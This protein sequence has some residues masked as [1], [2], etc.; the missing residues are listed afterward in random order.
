MALSISPETLATYSEYIFKKLADLGCHLRPNPTNPVVW[1]YTTF[2]GLHGILETDSIFSTHIAS[3][4][5]AT[6]VKYASALFIEELQKHSM[7]FPLGSAASRMIYKFVA[8]LRPKGYQSE[9]ISVRP[10]YLACLSENRDDLSQWRAY[11][12]GENGYALGMRLNDLRPHFSQIAPP[13]KVNYEAD[14]HRRIAA[15]SAAKTLEF[16]RGLDLAIDSAL[17]EDID[18]FLGVWDAQLALL[19]PMVKHPA[20]KGESEVRLIVQDHLAVNN[21]IVYRQRGGL[22][23]RHFPVKSQ[24]GSL[25]ISTVMVGPGRHQRANAEALRALL[26]KHERYRVSVEVSSSPYQSTGL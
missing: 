11:G 10:W 19:A 4:N 18:R 3:L 13:F 24:L 17:D 12:G 15:E 1:H 7:A 22:I 26:D 16:F 9:D 25:P 5:D 21:E 20:F 8:S 6:E 14:L 2:A 23:A